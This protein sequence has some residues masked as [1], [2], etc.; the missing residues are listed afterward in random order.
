MKI[1]TKIK[2]IGVGGAGSNTV[3]RL[4]L[5]KIEGV[6]LIALNTDAQDLKKTKA[7]Q[8][9]RIGKNLTKGLGAGMNP[10]IGRKAAEES[11]G[12]ISQILKDTD[13]VFI[14]AGLGGGTGSGA[15]PVVAEVAKNRKVL[16]VAVVTTPFSFEG[17]QRRVIAKA[18]L[19]NLKNK[20]DALLTISN[21]KILSLIDKNTTLIS[22]FL[23]CDEILKTAIQG[24][25]DLIL[26]PGLINVD[27][28]DV[29]A[30][31]EN[32]GT[33]LF[34]EG[35]AKGEKRATE[36]ALSAINSPLLD[37][38]VKGAKGV[39][40]NVSGG[41]LSLSE[42]E[43]VAEIITQNVDKS[44]KIIFG[45]VEDKKLPKEEIKITLLATGVS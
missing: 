2:V 29:K 13:M 19:E 21:D 5:S 28:A 35:R 37:F 33:A 36:A 8:K 26:V 45:A 38:S 24:I 4:F 18:A 25:S 15:S 32:S 12:E 34:G 6:E 11:R 31:L 20:V 40:F 3:S 42:I 14:N 43:T 17:L 27:F 44:A 1:N 30:I 22:A 39:L 10:E 9:L 41:K 23:T 7:H 16:T